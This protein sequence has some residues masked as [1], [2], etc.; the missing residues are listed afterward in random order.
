MILITHNYYSESIAMATEIRILLPDQEPERTVFLLSPEGCSGLEWITNTKVF[1]LCDL[2]RTAYVLVPSL[3]GCYTDMEYGYKFF[4]SLKECI[5]YLNTN[6]PG[7]PILERCCFA[8][9]VSSGGFA[10]L[11][12]AQEMPSFFAG[13]ASFSGILD[14]TLS[15][16]GWFTEKRLLCLHGDED[17]RLKKQ[18][19]FE[20][21]CRKAE[22]Q[23]FRICTKSQDFGSESSVRIANLLGKRA[24]LVSGAGTSDWKTW[25]DWLGKY[26]EEIGGIN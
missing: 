13:A 26:M 2:Y 11:K 23:S 17:Q 9:G 12:L 3:E 15:P 21:L 10:A 19:D 20:N 18:I 25:S 6:F 16:S 4:S 14:L 24:N 22:G 1:V 5:R 7:I 8:V